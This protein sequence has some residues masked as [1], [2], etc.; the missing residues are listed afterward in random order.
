MRD[1]V[2]IRATLNG[3]P[4]AQI[5][6]RH[7]HDIPGSSRSAS[8]WANTQTVSFVLHQ[9]NNRITHGKC[10]LLMVWLSVPEGGHC[11]RRDSEARLGREDRV[12]RRSILRSAWCDAALLD[13]C[14]GL[15]RQRLHRR[16]G[17]R[18]VV[19]PRLPVHPRIRH[20]AAAR[21]QHRAHRSVPVSKDA[22]RQLLRTRPLHPRALLAG[23]SQHRAR[24]RTICPAPGSP[25]PPT[26][27]PRPSSTSSTR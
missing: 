14:R 15:R 17:I 26:S 3:F 16:S 12:R 2:S 20:A 21:C 9:R 24:R 25:T 19:D 6:G 11:D 10:G 23:P 8:R 27:A 1:V 22:E 13:P 7:R 4:A 5:T 18:R